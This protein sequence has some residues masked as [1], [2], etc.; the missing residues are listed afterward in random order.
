MRVRVVLQMLVIAFAVGVAFTVYWNWRPAPVSAARERVPSPGQPDV[1]E[2]ASPGADDDRE[3][4]ALTEN[5]YIVE[6]KNGRDTFA[7]W[8][9]EQVDYEDGW[10]TWEQVRVLIYGRDGDDDDVEIRSD[11]ARTAGTGGSDFDE[12]VFIGNVLVTLPSGGHF[13]TRRIDYDAVTGEVSNCNRNILEYAGL[14]V[15]ADCMRFQTAGEVTNASAVA[16]ELLMW[17]DLV[18]RTA[19]D[20]DSGGMPSGLTGKAQEMRFRP[21]GEFVRLGG[22]PQVTLGEVVIR[23]EE[24]VLDVGADADE[25]RGLVATGT[26]RVRLGGPP[27]DAEDAAA[28]EMEA[29]ARSTSGQTLTGD[30]IEIAMAAEGGGVEVI[31][32][33]TVAGEPARLTLGGFGRIDAGGLEVTPGERLSARAWD[34]V[35]WT[36]RQ[37]SGGL[38]GLSAEGLLLTVAGDELESLEAGGRVS[39]TLPG[40]DG[41][42]RA[43]KGERL[44][45][46]WE[47][48][49]M[50]WGVWPEGISLDIDG[51]SLQAGRATFNAVTESWVLADYA[52]A[53][54][55]SEGVPRVSAAEFEFVATTMRLSPDGGLEA[56]GLVNGTIGRNYLAAAAALFG[57]AEAVEL[58][59]ARARVG[60]DGGL[61]LL[62]KV[63]IVWQTQS[64]VANDILMEA[65][66]GRLRARGDVELVAV[67]GAESEYVTVAAENLL[68]EE[69]ASEVRLGGTAE[70][71]QGRRRISAETMVVLVDENGDWNRVTAETLVEFEEDRAHGSGD[72]LEYSMTTRDLRLIGTESVPALFVYEG[73]DPPAE[74]RSDEELRVSYAGD[75]IVIESTADGRA[76]TSVV[77]R[78]IQQ[79]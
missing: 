23:G 77:P 20:D 66:P 57:D 21:G 16:E 17:Q 12:V 8:A 19:E 54:T 55:G 28:D 50:S 9:E 39:A 32:A 34:E 14:E 56:N 27:A 75:G 4:A 59:A 78:E 2:G 63:E 3:V 1:A 15:R 7:I 37:G 25:L 60:V 41:G 68:V 69:A 33:T 73:V 43:F 70:L 61:R 38:S 22:Q 46:G 31:T 76:T 18:I 53:G 65:D 52:G 10:N 24:L 51:R 6:S 5:I 58:R 71:R 30:E 72:E 13:A 74:Y 49:A 64:L 48:G 47:G 36:P 26:A 45:L 79:Q 29:A 62:G 44:E 40:E 35:V 67:T 11:R 42:A